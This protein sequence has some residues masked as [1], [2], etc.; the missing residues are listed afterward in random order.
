MSLVCFPTSLLLVGGAP[1]TQVAMRRDAESVKW[2]VCHP[3]PQMAIPGEHN[4]DLGTKT[5]K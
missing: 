1:G 4:P 3:G 5:P 2:F